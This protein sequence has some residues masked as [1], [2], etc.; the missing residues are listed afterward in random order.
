MVLRG[1]GLG[2]SAD[3][4]EEG[5]ENKF[6]MDPRVESERILDQIEDLLRE[7]NLARG[8]RDASVNKDTGHEQSDECASDLE[9]AQEEEVR[10][11]NGS[12][13]TLRLNALELNAPLRGYPDLPNKPIRPEVEQRNRGRLRAIC[14]AHAT[15]HP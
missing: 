2:D 14:Q 8:M 10:S 9:K 3:F 5:K 15:R 1:G 11:F 4:E 12:G 7:G 6:K 13:L